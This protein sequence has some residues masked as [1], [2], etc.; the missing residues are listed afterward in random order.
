M[1]NKTHNPP[2][3]ISIN[4]KRLWNSLMQ[5]AEIGKTE[6]GGVNRQALTDLDKKGRKLYCKSE[7]KTKVKIG[8]KFV[9]LIET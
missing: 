6:L 8:P 3:N 9:K 4:E 7:T 5:M 1:Q 2:N